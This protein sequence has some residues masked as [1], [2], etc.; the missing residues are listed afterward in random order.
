MTETA[1][2]SGLRCVCG[3]LRRRHGPFETGPAGRC[4]AS[5]GAHPCACWRFA[6]DDPDWEERVADV[7]SAYVDLLNERPRDPG[8]P[9]PFFV[10]FP[11]R[12][13]SGFYALPRALHPHVRGLMRT[14]WKVHRVAEMETSMNTLRPPE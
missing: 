11:H 1:I 10:G 6:P 3:H 13:F 2:P 12:F 5:R 8:R 14:A 7:L 4:E 9:P